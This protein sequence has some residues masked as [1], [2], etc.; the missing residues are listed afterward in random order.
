MLVELYYEY[1]PVITSRFLYNLDLTITEVASM[2]ERDRRDLSQVYNT[3][4]VDQN[5]CNELDTNTTN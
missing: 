4:N 5:M 1:R 3:E 2:P